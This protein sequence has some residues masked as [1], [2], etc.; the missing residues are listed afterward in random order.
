MNPQSAFTV[1]RRADVVARRY[2][3]AVGFEAQLADGP[4]GVTVL[5]EPI[6]V[7]RLGD[8]LLAAADRCPHRSSQLSTGDVRVAPSGAA[9]LVCPYHALHFDE[10]GRATHLPA[11]PDDR[12][13]ER[14]DLTVYPITVEHG[15]VWV[16]LDPDP[17]GGIPDWSAYGQ[18]ETIGF[19]LGPE[20][21][22]TM[23][24]RIVE[25]F[26]DLGH[27]ATVHAETFGASDDPALVTV[28]PARVDVTG[29]GGAGGPTGL[30]HVVEMY[31]LD[32]VTLDGPLV[33]ILAEFAYRHVFPFVTEL[34]ITYA[35]DR[36]E[37]IQ[38]AFTPVSSLAADAPRSLVFQ[39][40]VRNFDLDGEIDPWHD[41]QAAV[42]A[43]DREI[44][45]V[46]RP[47]VIGV[48]GTGADE[49]T[50]SFD[51]VTV[52]YRRLWRDLIG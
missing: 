25:N 52:A 31:Q 8:E 26:N 10:S 50:L 44:L 16:S 14:L 36:V 24:S 1:N 29:S 49:A 15:M 7:A 48:D 27:F 39:Q 20:P 12:L 19:Q 47:A 40:N 37:W 42:N 35:P 9:C 30:D 41:F 4:F 2:W 33:P 3:H 51:D 45:E 23:P 43:E 32:R 46:L 38:V 18:P 5:D 11:R 28:P 6:V 34:R 21:W 22:A 13:A 17:I